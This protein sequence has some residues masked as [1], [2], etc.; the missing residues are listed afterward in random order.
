MGDRDI[1]V[2]VS[3]KMGDFYHGKKFLLVLSGKED[4]KI[5]LRCDTVFINET[6]ID[7]EKTEK[8]C[9]N[10]PDAFYVEDARVLFS[11]HSSQLSKFSSEYALLL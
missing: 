3:T 1:Y 9:Q 8:V 2:P 6:F 5:S 10:V 11:F 7:T 4:H